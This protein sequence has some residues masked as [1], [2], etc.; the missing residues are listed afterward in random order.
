MHYLVSREMMM[1]KKG[2]QY[3][4]KSRADVWLTVQSHTYAV[5]L[6]ILIC[7]EGVFTSSKRISGLAT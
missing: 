3:T 1:N 6:G 4:T 7:R 5:R 2:L